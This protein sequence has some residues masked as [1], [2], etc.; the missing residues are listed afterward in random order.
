M[1]NS[2]GCNLLAAWK[3]ASLLQAKLEQQFR[4]PKS[5]GHTMQHETSSILNA[6]RSQ[7][8]NPHGPSETLECP[9]PKPQFSHVSLAPIA[10]P[11]PCSRP[12]PKLLGLPETAVTTWAKLGRRKSNFLAVVCQIPSDVICQTA[13]KH[14]SLRETQFEH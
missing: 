2:L 4:R 8:V 12:S 13:W 14:A 11:W 1:P 9:S 5:S 6:Y 3:G 7:L 10:L